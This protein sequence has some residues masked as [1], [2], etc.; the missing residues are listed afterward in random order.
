[1]YYWNIHLLECLL[2][3]ETNKY[4]KLI[5]DAVSAYKPCPQENCSCHSSV[6]EKDLSP[7]MSGITKDMINSVK[8]K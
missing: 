8:D 1:M 5:Q 2:I 7:F 6:I 4:L 3:P